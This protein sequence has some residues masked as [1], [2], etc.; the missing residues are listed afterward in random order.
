MLTEMNYVCY[1]Y[2][3]NLIDKRELQEDGHKKITVVFLQISKGK[4]GW[5]FLSTVG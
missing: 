1:N 2:K 3:S 4:Q 5:V